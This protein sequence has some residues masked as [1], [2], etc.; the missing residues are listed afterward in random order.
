MTDK[1]YN[2]DRLRAQIARYGKEHNIPP[3]SRVESFMREY[4]AQLIA[5]HGGNDCV[6]VGATSLLIRIPDIRLT[7]DIDII[8]VLTLEKFVDL[9][10]TSISNDA[11]VPFTFRVAQRSR[12]KGVTDGQSLILSAFLNGEIFHRTKIDISNKAILPRDNLEAPRLSIP[13]NDDKQ[14]IRIPVLPL[15][16]YLA[17]KIETL[18]SIHY[19]HQGNPVYKHR[20]HDLA[21][22]ALVASN[23]VLP[24]RP[25]IDELVRRQ[26]AL[27]SF[28]I[29]DSFQIPDSTF[30]H[31]NWEISM[32]IKNLPDWLTLERAV[33]LA[34]SFLDPI[35]AIIGDGV[36][37]TLPKVWSPSTRA[38]DYPSELVERVHQDEKPVHSVKPVAPQPSSITVPNR[39]GIKQDKHHPRLR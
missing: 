31:A 11:S 29:P 23:L 12:I 5:A 2:R 39:R 36:L 27:Q 24:D 1:T 18:F 26:A 25:L 22:I 9:F 33:E 37:P 10:E 28:H 38:W 17:D 8:T 14:T 30:T 4:V 32:R 16:E 21:D 35:F 7:T 20:W 34:K 6:L 13:E 19:N 15:P 3:N